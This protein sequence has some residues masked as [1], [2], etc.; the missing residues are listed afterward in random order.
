MTTAPADAVERLLPAVLENMERLGYKRHRRDS[1]PLLFA[2]RATEH[3]ASQTAIYRALIPAQLWRRKSPDG[4]SWNNPADDL[5]DLAEKLALQRAAGGTDAFG[6]LQAETAGRSQTGIVG[7]ALWAR[8]WTLPTGTL[9][10]E[11]SALRSIRGERVLQEQPKRVGASLLNARDITGR[12]YQILRRDRGEPMYAATGAGVA[13]WHDLPNQSN[14][15]IGF[16]LEQ[17][18]AAL[19][20]GLLSLS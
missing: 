3:G 19:A 2:F 7:C 10:D 5:E 18:T 8:A 11:E 12:E 6:C 9:L 20:S 4:V 1:I 17:I 16:A 14:T 15:R 13:D